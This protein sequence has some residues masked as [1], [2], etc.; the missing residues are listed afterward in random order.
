[1]GAGQVGVRGHRGTVALAAL[2]ARSRMC[3]RDMDVAVGCGP[4]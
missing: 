3:I 4:I 2:A 1:M